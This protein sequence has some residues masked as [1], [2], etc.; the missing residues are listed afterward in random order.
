MRARQI[1]ATMNGLQVIGL[2]I[3]KHV[4]QIVPGCHK[5]V[6]TTGHGT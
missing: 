1:I 3:A 5:V 6:R 2:D 4:F